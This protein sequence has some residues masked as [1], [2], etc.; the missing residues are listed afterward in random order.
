MTEANTTKWAQLNWDEAAQQLDELRDLWPAQVPRDLVQSDWSGT[1][2]DRLERWAAERPDVTAIHFYGT[3]ISYAQLAQQ[4]A[5]TAGWLASHGVRPGDRVGDFMANCPQFIIVFLAVLR[6]GAVH[7][8]INPM[9]KSAELAHELRD[10]QPS[11][12]IAQSE[13]RPLIEDVVADLEGEIDAPAV[14]YTQ[15]GDMLTAPAVPAAPFPAA[16]GSSD[17]AEVLASDPA[18]AAPG[19]PDALAALNYTGGTTGLPKGCEH[20]QAHMVYTAVS[21]LASMGREPGAGGQVM[22]GFL[23][24]FWIAGEDFCILNP[25]VDGSTLVLMTR[26]HPQAALELMSSQGVTTMVAM[27][28]NYVELMDLDGF[29]GAD[30]SALETSRAVS[31]VRKLDP[32]LRAQ[33]RT[34]TGVTLSEAAFGMTETH[35]SDTFTTG[36]DTDD[37]DLRAEP[38]YC[39]YPV[40]GT[41]IITVDDELRPVPPG[42]TGQILLRSPSVLRAYYQRPQASADSIVDGWM[43]TGDTGRFDEHGA[44]TYLSRTK[45]MIKVSGMSVFP[46]EVE[47]LFKSHPDIVRIAVAPREDAERGQIPVAFI[48]TAPGTATTEADFEEWASGQMASYKVPEV[49][50]VAEMPMTVTGKIRKVALIEALAAED[51]SQGGDQ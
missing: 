24:I 17:W 34:A 29:A 30:T 40:P 39:G 35:T 41:S 31:F 42:T 33:W 37:Q 8:P 25:I 47:S 14:A 50:F 19:D 45:E 11:A 4:V 22:L 21:T 6:L 2:G 51:I 20:T 44:L 5:A 38:I 28:D 23:P 15:L 32:E 13:F 7:L 9:F 26:W 3:D 18:P 48:E 36:L 10:G 49:H 46:A 1:L 16:D 43:L 12:I 27:A